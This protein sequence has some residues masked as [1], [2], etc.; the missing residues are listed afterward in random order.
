[1]ILED[2]IK[3]A[4]EELREAQDRLK[5][6]RP[7]TAQMKKDMNKIKVLEN[8]LEIHML[9]Y[10]KLQSGNR[11]LREQIDVMRKEHRNLVRAN[12]SLLTDITKQSEEARR[13]N[14]LTQSG[15]RVTDE[16]NNQI[17]ALKAN[18]EDRK[19][20]F[21]TQ[22]KGL[23]ERLKEKEES[24]LETLAMNNKE[25][26]NPANGGGNHSL[27]RDKKNGGATAT[28][29]FSNPT[30]VLKLRLQRWTQNN[31][32]KK[33]LSDVYMRNVKVIEDSFAQ[34]TEATGIKNI[35]E[36]V[37]TFVKTEEQNYSLYNY[38][39]ML[40]NEIDSIEE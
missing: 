2:Q 23:Q 12:Q 40:N 13:V 38:V 8:N 19:H 39:N 37:T 31:R 14:M 10:S 17:L 28:E 4:Q 7:P 22:I 25:N 15:Q 1:M 36:I 34:I 30:A 21:E 6:V 32:E 11:S 35:N 20:R 16:T 33:H 9:K 24:G 18:H 29:S 3:Q 26:N 27:T 5:K